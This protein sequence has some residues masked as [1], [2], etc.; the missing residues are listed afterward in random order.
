MFFLFV[1]LLGADREEDIEEK[2]RAEG[3]FSTDYP[4]WVGNI[5][6]SSLIVDDRLSKRRGRLCTVYFL[7]LL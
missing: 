3:L 2:G 6:E 4:L 1:Q 7:L 5:N